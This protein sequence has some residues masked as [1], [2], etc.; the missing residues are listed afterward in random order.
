MVGESEEGHYIGFYKHLKNNFNK[1]FFQFSTY[2]NYILCY[3]TAQQQL[4]QLYTISYELD[5]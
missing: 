1:V 5:K 2:F 3:I 4:N